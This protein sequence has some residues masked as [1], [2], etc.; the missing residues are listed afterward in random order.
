MKKTNFQRIISLILALVMLVG[1][2]S[3]NTFAADS[4]TEATAVPTVS[5]NIYFGEKI[6]LMFALPAADVEG[7]EIAINITD[8][9]NTYAVVEME[10]DTDNNLGK[11]LVAYRSKAGVAAQDIDKVFNVAVA[12]DG[13]EIANFTYSVLEYLYARLLTANNVSAEQRAM[14]ENL[15]AYADSADKVINKD[16]AGIADKYVYVT[17]VNCT[18]DGGKTAGIVAKDSVIADFDTDL[19]ATLTH[20]LQYKIEALASE[21]SDTKTAEEMVDGYIAAEHV[22]V[23]A[24][25][26]ENGYVEPD[27]EPSVKDVTKVLA[28][29]DFGANAATTGHNETTNSVANYQQT[30]GDYTLSLTNGQRVYPESYDEKGNSC[31]KFGTGSAVGSVLFVVPDDVSTVVIYVAGYKGSDANIVVNEAKYTIT[32]KSDD[33][34]YTAITVDTSTTK[35]VTFATESTGY[36]CMVDKIVYIGT[37]TV[38]AHDCAFAGATCVAKATCTECGAIDVDGDFGGHVWAEANCVSPATCTACGLTEGS[39]LGHSYD[40]GV[41]TTPA[42]CTTLGV[43]TFTC[44]ACGNEQTE[45][46]PNT[47]HSTDNGECEYCHEIIGGSTSAEPVTISRSVADLITE[48]GWTSSTTKQSFNLDGIVSVKINGGT[49]TGKAYDGD[50]L[51]IYATDSPAGTITISVADGYELVSIKIST[52]TGTYAFLYVDGTTTDICNKTVGVSGSSVKLNSVK[53]GSNGKQVRV[54]G[55]EVTYIAK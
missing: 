43:K 39:A 28:T 42:G 36:R 4:E 40:T 44:S 48:Y 38:P 18:F 31:I 37:I 45:S 54:T 6:H 51:R 22:K 53:N 16:A 34:I 32:T 26:V 1:M 2:V 10:P 46:I 5:K 33:G 11:D 55:I 52:Q 14:Y 19:V 9:E 7:A 24:Q 17:T 13:Q 49:N 25:L 29:F 30:S 35:N 15:I 21:A 20:D 50:H 3:I 8:G 47:G 23:T 12:I 41:I 27:P